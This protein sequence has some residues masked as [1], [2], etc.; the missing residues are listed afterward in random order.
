MGLVAAR[1]T[2]N[3]ITSPS[4]RLMQSGLPRHC[5]ATGNAQKPYPR[6]PSPHDHSALIFHR[7]FQSAREIGAACTKRARREGVAEWG[8]VFPGWTDKW[9]RATMQINPSAFW[10][11]G[12]VL[13]GTASLL[14]LHLFRPSFIL[15][16]W[17]RPLHTSL[18]HCPLAD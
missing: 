9:V 2:Q 11:G 1:V 12:W 16:T 6:R 14:W 18:T 10:K 13:D 17:L 7:T 5:T 4:I 15:P 3:P 8:I